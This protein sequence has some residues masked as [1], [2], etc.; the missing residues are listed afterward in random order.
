MTEINLLKESIIT[1]EAVSSG[2]LREISSEEMLDLITEETT[3]ISFSG[4]IVNLFIDLGAQKAVDRL[5]YV[6]NPLT[7]SGLSIQY[8]RDVGDLT[9]ATLVT[10]SGKII[11]YPTISGYTYP[12]YFS[13]THDS[14]TNSIEIERLAVINDGSTINFG[15]DGNTTVKSIVGTVVGGTSSVQEIPIKNDGLIVT[16]I[17]ASVDSA[18]VDVD[19]RNNLEIAPTETGTFQNYKKNLTTPDSIPWEWG[20]F[21]NVTVSKDN[22]LKIIDDSPEYSFSLGQV[23]NLTTEP[24]STVTNL[25]HTEKAYDIYN[26]ESIVRINEDHSLTFVD[27]VRNI[28]INSMTPSYA[29]SGVN[30]QHYTHPAW[31]G[32][33]RV[34]FLNGKSTQEIQQYNISSNT[35]EV[36]TTTSFYN[37]L[38]RAATVYDGYLYIAGG[39]N[40]SGSA[41]SVGDQ[42]WRIRLSDKTEEQL[43]NLPITPNSSMGPKICALDG[44]IYY[45]NGTTG[46]TIEFWRY[47]ISNNMWEQLPNFITEEP[48]DISPNESLKQV[49]VTRDQANRD[50]VL[51]YNVSTASWVDEPI[52]I[53]F[54]AEAGGVGIRDAVYYYT[55]ATQTRTLVLDEIRDPNMGVSTSGSWISPVYILNTEEELSRVLFDLQ[56]SEGVE[57]KF[58]DSV[59]VDNYQIRGSNLSPSA[60]NTF[61]FFEDGLDSD[62]FVFNTL[63]ENTNITSSGNKLTFSHLAGD[64]DY[65]AGYIYFGFGLSTAGVMQYKFW[66]N[67]STDKNNNSDILSKFYIVP[68]VD[69]L[70]EGTSVQRDLETLDRIGDEYVYL[71]FG[72]TTDTNGTF[73]KIN[74]FNGT[75]TTSYNI[76]AVS[77]TFYEV[78]LIVDWSTGDY[79]VYFD[80]DLVGTGTI[81]GIVISYLSPFH[82]YEFFSTGEQTDFDESFRYITIS[83]DSLEVISESVL[84]VP[85]HKEDPLFG[86][87][88]TLPWIPISV[89]SPL[90]PK[91]K[92]VQIRLTLK[93]NGFNNTP[94]INRV[95][96]PPVLKLENVG[97]GETQ[98]VY[99]RYVF[100]PANNLSTNT[101]SVKAWMFTDKL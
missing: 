58:D 87:N 43:T 42:F 36:F 61:Q 46:S 64:D 98:S 24:S 85:V 10:T 84:G 82:T 31:D 47:N 68:F 88:G 8:G 72:D 86:E 65:N 80:T 5:E 57:L 66:W 75:S 90:V 25:T 1:N 28:R 20:L 59:G 16:D 26:N 51:V 34:F 27:F 32:S 100:P 12:R 70:G 89:N 99:V 7:T 37:R 95:L 92:Y 63:S 29:V 41:S 53:T 14:E 30:E 54:Q 40:S 19:I 74:F 81:P 76:N 45:Y 77:G 21:T 62:E 2:T 56:E 52:S 48:R 55:S 96:F 79:K 44:Y 18:F 13:L 6:V 17:Y 73:T 15:K 60:Q 50:P 97:I 83:R 101:L 69:I 33:D 23:I 71:S 4:S 3:S 94:V 9:S 39:L 78:L 91:G 11:T 67:P 93:G 49:W 22:K 35:F 38:S